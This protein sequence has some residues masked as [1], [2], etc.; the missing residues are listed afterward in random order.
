L[1]AQNLPALICQ[2][3]SESILVRSVN[4]LGDAVMTTPALL[5]LREA[6]PGGAYH[7]A[8]A[9]KA[10]RALGAP[11][12]RGRGADVLGIGKLMASG[13]R[14]RERKFTA[15]SA[16]PNSIRS[17]LELWLAGHTQAHRRSAPR[18]IIIFDGDG[19]SATRRGGDAETLRRRT[20]TGALNM[21]REQ[22]AIRR[23]LIT[24]IITCA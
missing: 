13:R 16:F 12:F 14:L 23:K 6:R 19:P 18:S 17:A 8:L 21:P 7:P 5:R 20:F 1:R 10:G 2:R 11:A 15:R 22:L 9:G 3:R 24:S 4:W